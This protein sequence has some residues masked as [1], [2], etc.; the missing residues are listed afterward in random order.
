M[1]FHE[2]AT[3]I[4]TFIAISVTLI[5]VIWSGV[6][7]RESNKITVKSNELVEQDLELRHR[8]WIIITDPY[9]L[10]LNTKNKRYTLDEFEKMTEEEQKA[11]DIKSV[12]WNHHLKNTGLTPATNISYK[13][14]KSEKKITKED[15]Q[16]TKISGKNKTLSPGQETIFYYESTN[17]LETKE[18][19]LMVVCEYDYV[20]HK[21]KVKKNSTGRIWEVFG[22]G[23]QGGDSW[24]EY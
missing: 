10:Y 2:I 24:M 23:W 5:G 3:L 4:A 7:T 13:T 6:L 9:V 21:Q 19:W 20:D 18:D 14:L 12:I 1:S 11:L 17:Y 16:N 22:I 8:P 15:F